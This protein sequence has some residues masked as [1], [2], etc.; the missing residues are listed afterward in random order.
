MRIVLALLMALVPAVAPAASLE[1]SYFASRAIYI[2]KFQKPGEFDDARIKEHE[3]A[4]ADL[5]KQLRQIVGPLDLKGVAAESKI[6][7]DTLIKGDEG[8]GMLDG[9]VYASDD[10]KT[11][12]V[13]TNDLLFKRWLVEHRRWWREGNVPEEVNKALQSESFYTQAISTDSA[14]SKY[15]E[16][17]IKKPAKASFA[18]AMLNTRTQTDGPR[19][20]D[21]VI[22]SVLQGGR[23]YVVS[24]AAGVTIGPIPKCDA[25]WQEYEQKAQDAYA[26]GAQSDS[27]AKNRQDG[28]KVREQGDTA[29]HR[30]FAEQAPAEKAFAAL[31]QQAQTLADALPVK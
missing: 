15:A 12:I 5:L 16:L 18:F 28:S 27:K 2:K 14:V 20:A 23:V 10:D 9:V 29:Y 24:A 26:A 22:V 8:F 31:V 13:V 30:C 21:N 6:N 3:L 4:L 25:V 17:P 11:R 1:A 7:L 19:P